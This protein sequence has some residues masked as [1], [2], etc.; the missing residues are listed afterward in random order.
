MSFVDTRGSNFTL[1]QR[2]LILPFIVAA[3]FKHWEKYFKEDVET[4][5]KGVLK[6]VG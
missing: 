6:Y 3:I 4:L 5:L 1:Q 2:R